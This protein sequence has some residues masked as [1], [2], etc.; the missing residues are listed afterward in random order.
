MANRREADEVERLRA[1]IAAMHEAVLE[2]ELRPPEATYV[3][4]RRE[5]AEAPLQYYAMKPERVSGF[6]AALVD[7]WRSEAIGRWA[8]EFRTA[9]DRANFAETQSAALREEVAGL[10]AVL[11]RLEWADHV[12][13]RAGVRM[14]DPNTGAREEASAALASTSGEAEPNPPKAVGVPSAR[15]PEPGVQQVRPPTG[16]E[17]AGHDGETYTTRRGGKSG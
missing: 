15:K 12:A 2:A 16:P 17:G 4:M 9:R 6:Y 11:G 1:H 3:E 14:D 10:Q 5:G 8:E 13:K 7:R